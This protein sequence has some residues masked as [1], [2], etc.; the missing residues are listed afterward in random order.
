VRLILLIAASIVC[1][2]ANL[3][4]NPGFENGFGVNGIAQGW[5]N[6]AFGAN[7][8]TFSPDSVTPHSGRYAQKITCASFTDGAVQFALNPGISISNGRPYELKVWLKGTVTG[9]VGVQLRKWAWPYTSYCVK[10]F[11]VTP[12]WQEYSF[13]DFSVGS[14]NNA[15]FFFYF[16]STGFLEVDDVSCGMTSD[17]INLTDFVTPAAPV[18]DSLFGNHMHRVWYKTPWPNVTFKVWRLW[19]A[20]ATWE[21]IEPSKGAWDFRML[22]IYFGKADSN[23]ADLIMPLANSPVWA[24]ARPTEPGPYGPGLSAEPADTNDWKTYVQTVAQY[25]K[26]NSKGRVRYFEI[27]NE[28]GF[29]SGSFFS[30]TEEKLIELSAQAYRIIK[31]IDPSYQVISSSIVGNPDLF[32]EYMRK[33]AGQWCDI[34][35]YHFY[36]GT[37]E[38][39]LP[40]IGKIRLTM[41]NTGIAGKPLWNTEAGWFLKEPPDS[42]YI[43]FKTAGEYILRNYI[44]N[45]AAGIRTWCFYSWDNTLMGAL[46]M[47]FDG[48]NWAPVS[49]RPEVAG[50]YRTANGWLIGATMTSCRLDSATGTW[51]AGL[52][53]NSQRQL[54]VWNPDTSKGFVFPT[55][56]HFTTRT[57]IVGH[58]SDVSALS[59]ITVGPSPVLLKE[60]GTG[61]EAGNSGAWGKWESSAFPNPANPATVICF[62]MPANIGAEYSLYDISGTRIWK[63]AIKASA[64]TGTRRIFWPGCDLSGR[65]VSSGLYFGVL[66][67]GDREAVRHRLVLLK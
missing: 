7:T 46:N 23:Q 43:S 63:A 42:S 50:G 14:D 66:T 52:L 62:R 37:P 13:V 5:V 59:G 17:S 56:W 19:D 31:Q 4:P 27:W 54:I 41:K 39:I 53:R 51:S 67:V 11:T 55:G 49:E 1:A 6:N 2:Q 9:K 8:A 33:G 61:I 36:T 45:W 3:V 18:T 60:S 65:P 40:H 64:L 32:D 34:V 30:G 35:G 20:Y 16:S 48:T 10:E 24:S 47:V 25:C 26:D 38:K 12:Q 21:R 22:D 29:Y 58:D 28:P 57:D 44:L 15:A